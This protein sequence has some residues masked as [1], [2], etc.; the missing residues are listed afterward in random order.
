MSTGTPVTVG[1]EL[2]EYEI[3]DQAYNTKPPSAKHAQRKWSL[4]MA[5]KRINIS[6][7]LVID[8]CAGGGILTKGFAPH[9]LLFDLKPKPGLGIIAKDL[10]TL[11]EDDLPANDPRARIV[12]AN[13]PFNRDF[14]YRFFKHMDTLKPSLMLLILPDR[15]R[16]DP[17]M[18]HGWRCVRHGPMP[19]NSFENQMKEDG[20]V[21]VRVSWQVWEPCEQEAPG[22][23]WNTEWLARVDGEHDGDTRPEFFV[24]PRNPKNCKGGMRTCKLT[25]PASHNGLVGIRKAARKK[26]RRVPPQLITTT[27]GR[28]S[29]VSNR[30]SPLPRIAVSFGA[31]LDWAPGEKRK[32][33]EEVLVEMWEEHPEYT[34][35]ALRPLDI[36]LALYEALTTRQSAH[37]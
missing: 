32:F 25:G 20:C 17:E 33:L 21:C 28:P 11:T 16:A 1:A 12:V 35:R 31:E 4:Y 6:L 9:A 22:Q 19:P 5:T 18:L 24:L 15:F 30:E 14:V 23:P 2:P 8:P 36:K 26:A 29:A 10:F 34:E 3:K 13:P 37:R 7:C 27:K